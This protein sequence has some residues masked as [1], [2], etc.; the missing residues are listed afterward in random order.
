LRLKDDVGHQGLRVGLCK[1]HWNGV[2]IRRGAVHNDFVVRCVL[3]ARPHP[4]SNG[5]AGT[6]PKFRCE[7]HR[8]V[9]LSINDG[10]L[11]CAGIG[12]CMCNCTTSSTG[13]DDKDTLAHNRVTSL[14]QSTYESLAIEVVTEETPIGALPDGIYRAS[15]Q[16]TWPKFVHESS[17]FNLVGNGNDQALPVVYL[18]KQ[19]QQALQ[20]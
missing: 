9:D 7:P 18:S 5:C 6:L 2:P 8:P 11:C 12:Y 16:G 3:F 15:A 14:T 10:D 1:V 4:L 19:C 20:R 17:H 13:A